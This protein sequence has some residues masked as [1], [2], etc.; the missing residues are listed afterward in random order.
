MGQTG[1]WRDVPCSPPCANRLFRLGLRDG[2]ERGEVSTRPYKGACVYI[3]L[4]PLYAYT[5]DIGQQ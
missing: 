3:Y 4:Y 5:G 1:H 2:R